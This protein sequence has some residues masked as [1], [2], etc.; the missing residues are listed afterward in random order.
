MSA[1]VFNGYTPE[2]VVRILEQIAS[3][4][5][6]ACDICRVEADRAGTS[7][8]ALTLHALDTMLCGVGAL[9]DCPTGG[10]VVG[11]FAD[12]MM[13]PLFHPKPTI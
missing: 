10:G 6:L 7:D 2:Q 11:G 4:I 1:N 12:W 5:N 8:V 13:G 3:T 9:A